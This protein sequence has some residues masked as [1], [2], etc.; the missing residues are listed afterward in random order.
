M[1]ELYSGT[2]G[3][4][5]SFHACKRI[6]DKLRRGGKVIANFPVNLPPFA[7]KHFKGTFEYCPNETLTVKNLLLYEQK[8]H[9]K[10][11]EHQ[12]LVVIDEAGILFNARTWRDSERMNWLK[13]LALHRH[14]GFDFILVAQQDYQI[15]KQI[16]GYI[17]YEVIHRKCLSGGLAGLL[18]IFAGTFMAIKKYYG[19]STRLGT[20]FIRYSKKIAGIYDT[21]AIF[22][23]EYNLDELLIGESEEEDQDRREKRYA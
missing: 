12:T 7:K 14:H 17:E 16:R 23:E 11:K 20:E 13:F 3:S 6:Y 4:G 10:R 1:I 19:N 22:E 8:F 9:T 15:D 5:K 21:F 2:P 18:L